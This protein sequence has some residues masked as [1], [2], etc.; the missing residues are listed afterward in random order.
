MLGSSEKPIKSLAPAAVEDCRCAL[1]WVIQNA[2]QYG[3]DP[4]S[5][6]ITGGSAGGHLA[7]ITAMLPESAG[8]E[9]RYFN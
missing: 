3:I 5:L 6:V 4:D 9:H 7:L 1:R 8:L 2:K